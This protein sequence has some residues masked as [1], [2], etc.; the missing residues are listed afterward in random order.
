MHIYIYIH[1][2]NYIY[3]ARQRFRDTS[4]LP[5]EAMKPSFSWCSH[6]VVRGF[7]KAVRGL[8]VGS[9]EFQV[10][11]FLLGEVFIFV[12]LCFPFVDMCGSMI[13]ELGFGHLHIQQ[14]GEK[15]TVTIPAEARISAVYCSM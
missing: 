5:C 6:Q 1:A 9:L 15:K 4:S 11:S 7:D 8:K 10:V 3:I 12:F 14:V 13:S 2:V